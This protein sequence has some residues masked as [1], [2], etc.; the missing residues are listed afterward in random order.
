MKIHIYNYNILG[1]NFV[2]SVQPN[3]INI[4]IV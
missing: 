4:Q 1:S 3:N 2:K